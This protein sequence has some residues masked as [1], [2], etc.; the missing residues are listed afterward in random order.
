MSC[1]L[2]ICNRCKGRELLD[3]STENQLRIL[4]GR[5]FGDSQ[6]MFASH[7]NTMPTVL[8]IICLSL[9]I[10]YR[11]YFTLMLPLIFIDCLTILN[12]NTSKITL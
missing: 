5:S 6:G 1:E 12:F 11:K 7:I 10:C 3:F 4:N 2:R 8:R 9:K